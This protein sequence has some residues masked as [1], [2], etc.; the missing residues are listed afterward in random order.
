MVT[1]RFN[2]FGTIHKAIR[3]ALAETLVRMG[4]ATFEDATASAATVRDLDATL[5]LCGR[6][7]DA[8]ERFARPACA[9]RVALHAFDSGHPEHLR[10]IAE[11]RSLAKALEA[12]PAERRADAGRALYL[13]FAAFVGDSLL[14][15]AEEE[16]VLL[17]LLHRVFSDAELIAVHDQIVA[18]LSPAERAASMPTILRAVNSTERA[19]IVSGMLAQAPRD[20]VRAMIHAA[21]A[22]LGDLHDELA[23][24][25]DA[26]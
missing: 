22:G 26:A 18:S 21:R 10:Y 17:S 14:H 24:L 15:M 11:L 8:E 23:A 7:L 19:E 9:G 16:G 20:A 25:V 13:H 12:A 2:P 4:R 1:A 6:H 3:A 5:D